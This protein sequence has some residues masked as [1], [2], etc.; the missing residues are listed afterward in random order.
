MSVEAVL[1]RISELQGVLSPAAAPVSAPASSAV[2]APGATDG[3]TSSF[4][5]MLGQAG[6]TGT[7]TPGTT[8]AL[9]GAT[10]LPVGGTIGTGAVTGATALA[11]PG[12]SDPGARMVALAQGELAAGIAEQPPGSND[13]PRIAQYRTATTPG[14]VGP[15]CAYFV[16]WLANQAG[17][18]VGEA[19][20]GFA[21]VD[22][23][24][25][26]AQRTGRATQTP[27]PGEL[28]V[29]DEHIGLVTGV[30]PDGSIHTIE[31]NSSNKVSAR[32]YG[33][34]GGGALTYVKLG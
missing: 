30:D 34:G 8:A 29:W 26:W 7:A 21:N 5:A 2:A 12:A 18:P 3:G 15:W 10:T 9:R 20:Q 17:V 4:A 24:A 31:G 32:T 25:A 13:S 6:A 33:P 22:A 16:S 28:I 23:L 1:A 27:A 11:V 19:G 14:G